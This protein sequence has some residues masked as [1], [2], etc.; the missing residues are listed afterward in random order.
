MTCREGQCPLIIK[1]GVA[2]IL[3][4]ST[5]EKEAKMAAV[6]QDTIVSLFYSRFHSKVKWNEYLLILGATNLIKMPLFL[7]A[8]R[9]NIAVIE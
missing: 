9:N 8:T 5:A 7:S 4:V 6:A 1:E 3:L 2:A